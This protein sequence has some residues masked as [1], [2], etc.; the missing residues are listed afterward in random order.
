MKTKKH[1]LEAA[2]LVTESANADGTWV[3]RLIAEGKGSSG[4]YTRELFE[5]HHHALDNLLSYKNHPNY[6]G[7]QGRDFTMI[8]G[9]IV[10]E[11]WVKDDEE[12][13]AGVYANYR[14]DP[15]LK[16]KLERYKSKLGLS[17]YIEGSGYFDENDEYIVDW[18]NPNDPFAS[19]DV[20]VAPGAKG[21]FEES[22]IPE[23]LKKIYSEQSED[24]K[25]AVTVAEEN[26][27]KME[28]E[29]QVKELT[30]LV[31]KLV[32][33]KEASVAEAAQVEADVEAAKVAAE[34]AVERVLAA[35]KAVEEADLL[36]SQREAIL[37]EAKQG[38]DVAPLI[39][40]AKTVKAEALKLAESVPPAHGA[41]LVEGATVTFGAFK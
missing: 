2:T 15:E 5:N 38:V 32:A 10:G 21:R 40:S 31:T 33:D 29:A 37:A 17:I 14:P 11:T 41:P 23:E 27:K 25:P 28:L 9:E 7:P 1:L 26:G 13:R 18:F 4:V 30:A 8:A 6:D 16:E 12:G 35:V 34:S 22:A 24:K 20:V 36:P 3:V 39:E 19:V